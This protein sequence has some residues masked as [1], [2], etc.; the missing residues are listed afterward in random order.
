MFDTFMQALPSVLDDC[1]NLGIDIEHAYYKH[2][3]TEMVTTVD[4]VGVQGYIA[5]SGEFVNE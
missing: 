5:P 3:P 1:L 2:L 4:K